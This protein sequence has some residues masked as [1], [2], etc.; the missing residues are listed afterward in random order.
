MC[1]GSVFDGHRL[2]TVSRRVDCSPFTCLMQDGGP[3]SACK[4]KKDNG[5]GTI[6][7]ILMAAAQPLQ[8]LVTFVNFWIHL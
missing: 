5:I 2:L 7:A 4:V 3:S 6:G 1:S 8:L